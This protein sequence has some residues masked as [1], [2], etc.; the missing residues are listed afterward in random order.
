VVWIKRKI[1]RIFSKTRLPADSRG[2]VHHECGAITELVAED[3]G[4]RICGTVSTA[5]SSSA[6]AIFTG[7]E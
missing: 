4:I 3:L 7:P 5:C 1:F 6:N 2:V